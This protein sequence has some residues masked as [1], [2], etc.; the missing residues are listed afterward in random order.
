MGM[1]EIGAGQRT[2]GTTERSGDGY[3]DPAGAGAALTAVAAAID[4]LAAA[5]LSLPGTGGV[6]DLLRGVERQTR[7]L[8]GLSVALVG[9][10]EQR[11]LA[12]PT[13]Q[14]STASL[15]RQVLNIGRGD[16]AARVR[17]AAKVCPATGFSG[18]EVLPALGHL[19][20]AV[21]TGAV[22]ARCADIIVHTFKAMPTGTDPELLDSV[23][24]FLV[25]QAELLDPKTFDGVARRVQ[26]AA[27]PDGTDDEKDAHER[28]EFHIGPR[29]P[30]GLTKVWGLL[31]DLTVEALRTAFGA[32]G[33]PAAQ[34]SRYAQPDV[35]GAT[36]AEPAATTPADAGPADGGLADAGPADGGSAE[37]IPN[38]IDVAQERGPLDRPPSAR[39]PDAAT[40]NVGA[41]APLPDRR[42]S[43]APPD[44][45]KSV[46][47]QDVW[48]SARPVLGA[49]GGAPESSGAAPSD[50]PIWR[51]S[52]P[53]YEWA[54]LGTLP[55]DYPPLTPRLFPEEPPGGQCEDPNVPPDRRTAGCRRA[56]ALGLM[57]RQFLESGTAPTQGG[58]RP[59]LLVV[60]D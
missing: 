58:Q 11:G 32:V 13:G 15:L 54:P 31:D 50:A 49:A 60:V 42:K 14:T 17:L 1:D 4:L 59:Q 20:A 52:R 28:Q 26:L 18:G 9:Q 38:R 25:E 7:R 55:G 2:G 23:G 22:G 44:P 29:R 19:A 35:D 3:F 16:A 34:R 51:P 41:P 56:Q 46:G 12:A 5:D 40:L 48:D 27:N 10:V 21:G 37:P 43:G 39:P 6:L 47:G 33:A 8:Y 57:I 30:S 45:P 53:P 24:E 36:D